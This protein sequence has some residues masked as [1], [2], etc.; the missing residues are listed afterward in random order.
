MANAESHDDGVLACPACGTRY[1]APSAVLDRPDATFRCTR[2][3]HV[4]S[5]DGSSDADDASGHS[6]DEDAGGS[7]YDVSFD[8]EDDGLGDDPAPADGSA[9][10]TDS[11]AFLRSAASVDEQEVELPPEPA[12]TISEPL[13]TMEGSAMTAAGVSWMR[14]GVR[15][16]ILVLL[17]FVAV[18]L[19]LAAYPQKALELIPSA[20]D[21]TIGTPGP[22]IDNIHLAELRG[23]PERLREDRPAFVITGRVINDSRVPVGA[24]QVEGRIYDA[25]QEVARKTVFAGTKASRRLVRSWS[26]AEI[27]MFE[28]ITPPKRYRLEPG[29]TDNFLI[30]FQ[31]IPDG[32]QEFGCRVVT[33]LP[34][35]GA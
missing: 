23:T 1:R 27:A 7:P 34:V 28:R 3:G 4:F 5:I 11:P 8:A 24:I 13:A 31:D 32:L 35:S 33:A 12:F 17:G 20:L 21:S 18:G 6:A 19:Y 26:A 15:F 14:I 2:C 25:T 30:I 16:E 9:Q 22:L 10:G 29:A